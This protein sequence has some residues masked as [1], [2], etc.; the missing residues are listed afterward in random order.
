MPSGIFHNFIVSSLP[1]AM[2]F[3]TGL[4]AIALNTSEFSPKKLI[5]LPS[6]IFHNLIV[7]SLQ[8]KAMILPFG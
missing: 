4:N 5:R 6:G 7:S 1:E 8:A 2:M 3:S